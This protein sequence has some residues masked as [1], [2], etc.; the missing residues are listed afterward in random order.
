MY[1]LFVGVTIGTSA[2]SIYF[3]Y[4]SFNVD[5][6]LNKIIKCDKMLLEEAT[7]Q[8]CIG[9]PYKYIEGEVI[10]RYLR[11]GNLSVLIEPSCNWATVYLEY[12]G[13]GKWKVIE[14]S[15]AP[16][17]NTAIKTLST[18]TFYMDAYLKTTILAVILSMCIRIS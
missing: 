3:L 1:K 17:A 7:K 14:F 4:K 9:N 13:D 6:N 12:T 15:D 5:A 11:Y 18:Q 16:H 2:L 10:G 8:I